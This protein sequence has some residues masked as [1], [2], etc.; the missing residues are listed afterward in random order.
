MAQREGRWVLRQL[1]PVTNKD[2]I[3]FRRKHVSHFQLVGK[4]MFHVY[5]TISGEKLIAFAAI[6]KK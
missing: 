5:T 4:N 3:A 1:W 2:T 6:G